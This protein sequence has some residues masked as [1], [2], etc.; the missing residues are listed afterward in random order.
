MV[1]V[2]GKELWSKSLKY[3]RLREPH[4]TK[5]VQDPAADAWNR[6]PVSIV[7]TA[8]R[9]RAPLLTDSSSSLVLPMPPSARRI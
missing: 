3:E 2:I 8:A 5:F 7:L 4:V 6:A 1:V 9:A